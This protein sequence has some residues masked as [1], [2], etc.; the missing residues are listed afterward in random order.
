MFFKNHSGKDLLHIRFSLHINPTHL[1]TKCSHCVSVVS[2][3][4]QDCQV[5][6][7]M[8]LYSRF[9]VWGFLWASTARSRENETVEVSERCHQPNQNLCR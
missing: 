5:I 1:Q 4:F 9:L 3:D 2:W 6:P 8:S 7:E